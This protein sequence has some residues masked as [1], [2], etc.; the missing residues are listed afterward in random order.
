MMKGTDT[1]SPK[2]NETKTVRK[3]GTPASLAK[4]KE[5]SQ[6]LSRLKPIKAKTSA[7][8]MIRKNKRQGI[9]CLP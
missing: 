9:S 5:I 7:K 2:A 4:P 1:T 3:T 6:V 8:I